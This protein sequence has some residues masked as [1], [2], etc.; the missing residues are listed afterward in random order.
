MEEIRNAVE[1][2]DKKNAPEEDG[3][4]G[5]IYEETFET[6]PRFITAMYNGC[7]KV[8]FSKRWKRAKLIPIVK[9]EKENSEDVLKYRPL[10]ILYFIGKGLEVIPINIIN[11]RV[12]STDFMNNYL[13]GFTQQKS[14]TDAANAVKGFVEESLK[15][16]RVLVLVSLDVKG[17][18][19]AAWW[20]N[21]LKSLQA[22]G[23][24]KSLYNIRR[25][26]FSQSTVILSTDSVRMKTEVG[27]EFQQ[28]SCCDPG[29]WNIQ[30]NSLLNLTFTRRTKAVAFA[31][32]FILVIRVNS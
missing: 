25:R 11:H 2:M 6:F 15:A 23:C 24:P 18:F 5:E 22:C 9:P 26:Y 12:Y 16:G 4:T 27:R 10:S 3:I 19:D 1:S 8:H 28:V 31:D 21:I 32:D 20:P 7:Y 17:D 14:S 30:Y 29:F 13:Y